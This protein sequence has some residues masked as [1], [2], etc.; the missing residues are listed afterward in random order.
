MA[1]RAAHEIEQAGNEVRMVATVNRQA[2]HEFDIRM[3]IHNKKRKSPT[4]LSGEK[5]R[6]GHGTQDDA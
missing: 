5:N 2:E 6:P 4:C 3:G 1:W